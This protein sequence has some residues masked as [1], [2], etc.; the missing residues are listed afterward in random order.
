MHAHGHRGVTTSDTFTFNVTVMPLAVSAQAGTAAT[1]AAGATLAQGTALASGIKAKTPS[2]VTTVTP[3]AGA[4]VQLVANGTPPAAV[5]YKCASSNGSV[6]ADVTV[7][8]STTTAVGLTFGAAADVFTATTVTFTCAL[9]AN[10]GGL[11]TADSFTFE[12]TV[13]PLMVDVYPSAVLAAA[14]GHTGLSTSTK[15]SS[16]GSLAKTVQL[17]AGV[18]YAAGST[19]AL[20]V[21]VAPTAAVSY[22]CTSSNK[23]VIGDVAA[24]SVSTTAAVN[25]ALPTP[26][27]VSAGTFVTFTC[28]P[29]AAASGFA[30]TVS[31]TFDVYV[32][33]PTAQ[34]MAGSAAGTAADG[35][36]TLTAGASI[37]GSGIASRTPVVYE[38][39][40]ASS[41]I[42]ALQATAP[43]QTATTYSCLGISTT[44]PSRPP[45][46]WDSWSR[47]PRPSLLTPR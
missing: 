25:L 18:T 14:D 12:V 20:K 11:T 32:S 34:V 33:N 21:N 17:Y 24:T 29:S 40:A 30:T 41:T 19:V 10:A 4:D 28:A 31:V 45:A 13:V 2:I 44:C 15:I 36:T 43:P 3:A 16:G 22:V 8:V 27:V 7:S 39:A 38:G 35:T 5:S 26:A 47:S 23:T 46:P 37:F 6:L 1:T 9:T 42:V